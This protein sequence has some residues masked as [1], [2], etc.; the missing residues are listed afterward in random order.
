MAQSPRVLRES[1]RPSPVWAAA[2]R[3][4]LADLATWD[5]THGDIAPTHWKHGAL[6]G[7]L[8]VGTGL[9]I[10]ASELCRGSEGGGDCGSTFA[11]GFIL[12]A[13]LGGTIGALI[14]GQ[15]PKEDQ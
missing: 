4:P 11:G 7:G 10:L 8:A 6:I 5:S 9:A 12:G 13:V 15:I 14:G 2:H 1:P 3:S